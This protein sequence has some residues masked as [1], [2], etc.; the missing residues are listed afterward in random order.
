MCAP[1][2]MPREAAVVR[3]GDDARHVRAVPELVAPG[4]PLRA[5]EVDAGDDAPAQRL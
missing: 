3:A 2:A 5:G 1:G 4:L